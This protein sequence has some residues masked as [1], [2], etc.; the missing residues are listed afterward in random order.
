MQMA[1]ETAFLASRFRG[2]LWGTYIGDALAMPVHWYYDLD[3]LERDFG[4]ITGYTAPKD[5]FPNSIMN[6]SNTGGGGRGSNKGSII[7][8]VICHG[9]KH[10]WERG[11]K[12]HYHHGMKAG[13]NTLDTLL[14]GLMISSMIEDGRFD[15]NLYRD[16]Y[17][18]FMT[19]PGSHNDTYAATA[20]RMFFANHVKGKDPSQCADNDGHNTDS[21][22]G[23]VNIGPVVLATLRESREVQDKAIADAVLVMRRSD[24]LVLFAQVYRDLLLDVLAGENLKQ[25]IRKC[26][27][28][29]GFDVES[30]SKQR[31]DPMSACYIESS[32]P[33]LL[34]FA[35]KYG[36]NPEQCLLASVNAGGENVNRSA[37]LGALLGAAH[38]DVCWSET[39][40]TGL[41][42][43]DEYVVQIDKFTEKFLTAECK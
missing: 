11:A 42:K 39:L 25:A 19:T 24:K 30:A 6:L 22:D 41:M 40:M 17:I 2:L 13:E 14:S 20:H 43:H 35:Y 9:K 23:L 27:A 8:D 31:K 21:I 37:V 28:R 32:F 38:G 12:K 16:R 15:A 1:S 18:A 7:G 29:L 10:L 33:A 5:T 3:Q 4:Q 34:V 26:A 36:D